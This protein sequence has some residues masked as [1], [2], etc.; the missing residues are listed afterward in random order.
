MCRRG[1]CDSL[2][3]MRW[4]DGLSKSQRIVVVVA[5]GL[6]L[7]VVGSYLLNLGSGYPFGWTGFSPLTLATYGYAGLHGWLRAIIWLVLIGLWAVASVRVLRPSS[8]NAA[9]RR[10]NG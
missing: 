2:P 7:G 3:L 5:F 4:I 1:E 6:A 10:D 8:E 9:A